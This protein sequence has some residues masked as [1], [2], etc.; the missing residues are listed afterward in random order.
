[1]ILKDIILDM[2]NMS[3]KFIN[4]EIEKIR[5][6][7]KSQNIFYEKN[8]LNESNINEFLCKGIKKSRLVDVDDRRRTISNI[9]TYSFIILINLS[10]FYNFIT[11]CMFYV[12]NY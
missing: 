10:T 3:E 12:F 5:E 4:F 8:T 11:F 7:I 1:M 6:Y 2:E 9:I